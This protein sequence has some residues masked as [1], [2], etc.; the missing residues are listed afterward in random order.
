MKTKIHIC[1]KRATE[2]SV[3]YHPVAEFI[4]KENCNILAYYIELDIGSFF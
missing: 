4:Y 2:R 1:S 3:I